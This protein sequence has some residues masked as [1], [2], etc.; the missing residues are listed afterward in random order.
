MSAM[1]Q[2]ISRALLS[3]QR[4][5]V[6]L[7]ACAHQLTNPWFL[8]RL[9]QHNTQQQRAAGLHCSSSTSHGHSSDEEGG[10]KET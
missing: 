9:N 4:S 6:A 8:L 2:A 10:P 3:Q 1:L 7:F 5:G